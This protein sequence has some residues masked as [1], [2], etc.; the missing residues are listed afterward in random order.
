VLDCWCR[1]LE[2]AA[3]ILFDFHYVHAVYH[4]HVKK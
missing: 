3:S 2:V 4:L 1:V